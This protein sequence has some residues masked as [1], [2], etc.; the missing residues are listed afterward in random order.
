MRK[1]RVRGPSGQHPK[2]MAFGVIVLLLAAACGTSG[3]EDATPTTLAAADVTSTVGSDTNDGTDTPTTAPAPV[4]AEEPPW[5]DQELVLTTVA[6]LD[7]AVALVP[8]SGTEDLYVASK[9]GAVHRITRTVAKNRPDRFNLDSTPVLDV[10]DQVSSGN[11]QGL[12]DLVFNSDGR[13][14]YLSY[15]DRS[16]ANVI[17]RYVMGSRTANVDTRRE[18]L[19]IEQPFSN[20]NGGGLTFGPDGFLYVGIGD[21]GRAGDP[22]GSGQDTTSLLGAILRIDP[23][24]AADG[25]GY[26]VPNSNPYVDGGGAPEVWLSGVRNPWQFSF[27]PADDALWVADVGQNRFEEITRL[28]D[29]GRGANLGWN[30]MEGNEP[31]EGGQEPEDHTGPWLTYSHENDRCSI[32]GGA[33]Y[34]G[35]TLPLYNGVYI[36]GDYCSGEIFGAS[37]SPGGVIFRK[38][39]LELGRNALGAF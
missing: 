18:V 39:N 38:L 31:Y 1:I 10:S 30:Q 8:R 16:G 11:E 37:D 15:T 5:A 6:E 4:I 28:A 26:S 33:V 3:T 2:A 25:L 7:Q 35:E 27:D 17:D 29:G 14:L 34:R 23:D 12:L 20:H 36:F 19:K 32:T 13:Q 22:L 24:G 9:T 21:G